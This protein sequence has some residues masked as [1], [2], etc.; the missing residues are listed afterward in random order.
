MY[1]YVGRVRT[2]T[3]SP[4]VPSSSASVPVLHVP[5]DHTHTPDDSDEAL[6]DDLISLASL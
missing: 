4:D 1:M 2:E 3:F 5:D 6:G